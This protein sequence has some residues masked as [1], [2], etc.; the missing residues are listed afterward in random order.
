M[1]SAVQYEDHL[2]RRVAEITQL[3]EKHRV[4]E[5]LAHRQE[6]PRR[7]LLEGLQHRQNLAEL[8]KHLRAM[9]AADI[10]YVLEALPLDERDTVWEQ[11]P[12]TMMGAVFVELSDPVRRSLGRAMARERLAALLL[13][14]DPE[15]L[16]YVSESV[17]EDVLSEV[18]RALATAERS[19]FED[20]VAFPDDCV[21]HFTTREWAAVPETFTV[22]Q[23]VSDL[24]RRGELPPQTDRIFVVDVRNILRG[25]IPLHALI[26]RPPSTPIVSMLSE[27]ALSF[28]PDD[29]VAD[30]AKAFERRH[31]ASAPVIDSR[32]KLVGRLTIDSIIEFVKDESTRRELQQAGLNRDEDVFAPPWDSARNRWPWLG[33]NLVTAFVASRVI[34]RFED[35]I[36]QLAALAALMPIV[37]SI[38]GNTGNQTM[39]L[40]IRAFALNRIQVSGTRRLLVKELMVGVLNGT[41]WGLLVGV[42]S[43]L[44]YSSPALG[45]VMAAAVVL[46]LLVA[47]LSGVTIP[48]GLRATGYDPAYGSSVLLTFVTDAMGFFLFLGL[49]AAFLG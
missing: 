25:T 49:A 28:T 26:V 40:V 30:A 42:A 46:N 4:L 47:A 20:S 10:A 41:V 33:I 35:T 21:G 37:A 12:D 15:D 17:P 14:I 27:E 9:H 48:L 36:Q 38:G 32:G 19:A 39:A 8:H 5:H 3:L 29:N 18:S 6:G 24:R 13:Q 11:T 45:A 43:A 23:C 16:A 1:R 34:G 31:L 22:D 44:L 2:K 7:D